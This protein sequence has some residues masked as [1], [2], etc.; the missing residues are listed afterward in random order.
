MPSSESRVLV[1]NASPLI[2]LARIERLDLLTAVGNSVEIP[3][4]VM[5]EVSAGSERDGAGPRVQT[6]PGL[7]VV[8][9]IEVPKTID[10]WDLG[11][12]ES[13]V[14][15]RALADRREA[16]VDDRAARRCAESLGLQVVGTVGIIASARKAG[17]ISAA[18]PL[19]DALLEQGLRLSPILLRAV[20]SELG[21]R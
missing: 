13:Q 19:L 1:V 11:L 2:L 15:A 17:I 3:A 18:R 4:A 5:Q 8:P 10:A 9:D 6:T 14:I 7:D 20:L 12:G 16:V 21:E